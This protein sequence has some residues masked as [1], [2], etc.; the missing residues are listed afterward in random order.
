MA[1]STGKFAFSTTTTSSYDG[2]AM[3]DHANHH[4]RFGSGPDAQFYTDK[5]GRCRL[6]S[7]EPVLKA[8]GF[9]D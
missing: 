2:R 4:A 6:N 7:Y 3:Y 9:N 5:V 1:L 8:A